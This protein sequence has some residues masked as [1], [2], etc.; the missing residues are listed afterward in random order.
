MLGGQSR[1]LALQASHSSV[2][3]GGTGPQT[4]SP[5]NRDNSVPLPSVTAQCL[6]VRLHRACDRDPRAYSAQAPGGYEG[7]D[8]PSS[9][10]TGNHQIFSSSATVGEGKGKQVSRAL[11]WRA[12][13]PFALALSVFRGS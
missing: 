13:F 12:I 2:T 7:A 4:V 10:S 11:A 1:S 5:N 8:G 9:A 6:Q 3:Q